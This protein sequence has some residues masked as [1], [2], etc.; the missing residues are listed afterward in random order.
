M[1]VI[2]NVIEANSPGVLDYLLYP[3]QN[4]INQSWLYQQVATMSN[5]LNDIGKQF[6]DGSKDIYAK[7]NDADMIRKAKAAIKSAI[8]ISFINEVVYYNS[9]EAIMAAT[10]YMQNYLMANPTIRDLYN[11]QL[12]DGYSGTYV[13]VFPGTIGDTHYHYRR[14]M[15]GVIQDIEDADGNY[16]W[17]AKTYM[18]ELFHGDREL[19]ISEKSKILATWEVMDLFIKQRK[20]PTK[21]NG[22]NL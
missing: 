17:I 21:V 13:D 11:T 15:D 3:E 10:P 2:A 20:D 18:D 8:G 9:L 1:T 4:P 16:Q 12:C 14:V 22:G 7:I 6:M 5:T 19:D